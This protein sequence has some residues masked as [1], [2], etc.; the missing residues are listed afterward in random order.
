MSHHAYQ[1]YAHITW[2]T[3]ERVGCV[4]AQSAQDVVIASECASRRTLVKV[5]RCAVLSD[6][7]HVLVSYRTDGRVRDFVSLAKS[8][9]AY[10]ANKRIPGALKWARGF[11]VASYHKKDLPRIAAYIAG[12]LARH[13]ER[14]PRP[15]RHSFL[16]PG[17]SPGL[18][19]GRTSH[20]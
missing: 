2:H 14:V 4:D 8:I 12:Q 3:W 13:P 19:Q 20:T 16:T 11:Y 17:D 15:A 6:H 10:R 9:S 18:T 5:L 7:V 1:L